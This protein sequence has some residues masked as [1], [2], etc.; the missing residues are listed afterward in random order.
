MEGSYLRRDVSPANREAL[1]SA[2]ARHPPVRLRGAW[3][4]TAALAVW[5]A[6]E[7]GAPS[8]GFGCLSSVSGVSVGLSAFHL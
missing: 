6:L 2:E 5:T 4:R 7:Q 3:R 8:A 1:A